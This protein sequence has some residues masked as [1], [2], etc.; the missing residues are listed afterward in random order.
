MNKKINLSDDGDNFIREIKQIHNSRY[1]A[2]LKKDL[3]NGKVNSTIRR[4]AG[5]KIS[6]NLDQTIKDY[7]DIQEK[8]AEDMLSL[9][10]NLKEQ[11]ETANKIIKKDTE[12]SYSKMYRFH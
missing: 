2:N 1:E 6:E 11:T 4:R 10:I 12:V 5:L 3:F 9:T 7:S 8:L